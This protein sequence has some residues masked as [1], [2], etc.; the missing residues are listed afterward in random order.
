MKTSSKDC[1]LLCVKL[2]LPSC[3]TPGWCLTISYFTPLRPV[4][5]SSGWDRWTDINIGTII[6]MDIWTDIFIVRTM[7][8]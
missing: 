4:L 5:S 2:C 3:L 7:D 8:R 6:T 1:K